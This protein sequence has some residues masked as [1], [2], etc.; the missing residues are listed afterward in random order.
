M[1]SLEKYLNEATRGLFGKRKKAVQLELRGAI[2]DK[3]HRYRVAGLGEGQALERAIKD[4]GNARAVQGGFFRLHSAPLLGQ[5]GALILASSAAVL[6]LWPSSAAQVVA[7]TPSAT[8][9]LC[10]FSEKALSTLDINRAQS[11]RSALKS[12]PLEVLEESCRINQSSS[13]GGYIFLDRDSLALVL[14]KAGAT[15]SQTALGGL[16]VQLNDGRSRFF[17]DNQEKGQRISAS[18]FIASALQ[19]KVPVRLEGLVNP[20]LFIGQTSLVIGTAQTPV[21]LSTLLLNP[22]VLSTSVTK[23]FSSLDKEN[24]IIRFDLEH[25]AQKGKL[26]K[27]ER[28]IALPD[29]TLVLV[30]SRSLKGY[31]YDYVISEVLNG[32]VPLY[33]TQKDPAQVRLVDSWKALTEPGDDNRSLVLK[34]ERIDDLRY[35]NFK[36]L[37]ASLFK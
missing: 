24:V 37:P 14:G 31:G 30:V 20:R 18:G 8:R 15:V 1:N 17:T 16:D 3:Q 12:F 5:L 11:I 7:L 32:Q 27:L 25:K 4:L 34:L 36:I 29:K 33:V 26:P 6:A 2:E 22:P 19:A 9:I 10:D 23:L 13:E 35:L 28:K 21:S